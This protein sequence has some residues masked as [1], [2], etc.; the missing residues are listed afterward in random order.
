MVGRNNSAH[1][2]GVAQTNGY[3]FLMNTS[4]SNYAEA[5]LVFKYVPKQVRPQACKVK[6]HVRLNKI[7]R[8]HRSSGDVLT[9]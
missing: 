8:G 2:A 3:R 7:A 4:E 5:I 6:F 9:Q 1:R